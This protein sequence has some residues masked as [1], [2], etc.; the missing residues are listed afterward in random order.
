MKPQKDEHYDNVYLLYDTLRGK[1]ISSKVVSL[2]HEDIS[3]YQMAE[4][5]S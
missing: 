5:G 2:C 1:S 4:A 3:Y